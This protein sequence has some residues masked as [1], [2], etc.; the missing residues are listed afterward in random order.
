MFS[1]NFLNS[2]PAE[3]E[4]FP[5]TT[6][7]KDDPFWYLSGW[8]DTVDT[9]TTAGG[10]TG[11]GDIATTST[12]DSGVPTTSTTTDT[13]TLQLDDGHVADTGP[14]S[15]PAS[16]VALHHPVGISFSPE[17]TVLLAE[18]QKAAEDVSQLV[19]RFGFKMARN[20][21]Q[22]HIKK[23]L[24]ADRNQLRL[25]SLGYAASFTCWLIEIC[26]KPISLEGK[27]PLLW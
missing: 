23:A 5:R 24:F 27:A 6:S 8:S 20:F 26:E 2:F 4:P 13:D 16:N 3:A 14:Q 9:S 12:T 15:W 18:I 10:S 1:S 25:L 11:Y 22:S 7:M 21:Q 17:P 19:G